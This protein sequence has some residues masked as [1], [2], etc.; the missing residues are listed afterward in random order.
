MAELDN[1][2][3]KEKVLKYEAFVNDVLR[4]DLKHVHQQLE[5]KNSELAE[6][7][8]LK[9]MLSTLEENNL[10]NGFKTKMDIGTNVYAQAEVTDSS[11]VFINIGCNV[12]VEYNIKEA[13]RF[14]ERHISLLQKQ[15]TIIRSSSADIKARIKLV[16]H[17]IQELSNI[18]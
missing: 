5:K 6:W 14:I 1:A 7:V 16:L 18:K 13:L 15:V 9:T 12:Y 4:E 10:V 8:Q 3:I 11:V 17:G 2:E